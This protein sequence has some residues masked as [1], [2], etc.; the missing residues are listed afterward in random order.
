MSRQLPAQPNLEHLKKQA[1]VLLEDLTREN[2]N[3]KLADA[4]HAIAREY[5]FASWPKLKVHVLS[6]TDAVVA[7]ANPFTGEWIADF[8]R[9]TPRSADEPRAA[10]LQFAVAGDTVTIADTVVDMSGQERRGEN[11]LVAD[12]N[13]YVERGYG[14]AARWRDPRTL[15][16][17]VTQGGEEMARARYSVSSD[18]RTLTLVAAANAHNGYPATERLTVFTRG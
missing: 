8:A 6:T 17:V 9:S 18:A 12:G 16:V 7:D 1:K 10:R 14:T 2:P 11:M 4:L 5:G 3:A 15:E 13:E